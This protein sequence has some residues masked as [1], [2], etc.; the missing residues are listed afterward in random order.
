M[1]YNIV[2]VITNLSDAKLLFKKNLHPD[3]V[4]FR[5]DLSNSPF[6]TL[7]KI[8][9]LL[10]KT[11]IICTIRPKYEGGGYS[12]SEN[13]RL[14]LFEKLIPLC[15]IVDIELSSK[16]LKEVIRI[17]KKNKKKFIISY[18]NFDFTPSNN[19]L[20]KILK[21]GSKFSPWIIKIATLIK[22]DRDF[23][24][25]FDFCKKYTKIYPLGILPMGQK[26]IPGRIFF[27]FF[28]S[29]LA[30]GYASKEVAPGQTN[31]NSLINL[32]KIDPKK[33]QK[34]L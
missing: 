8:R 17:S 21:N 7:K 33:I 10:K 25:L 1:K 2:G 27:P 5:A 16:I 34:I 6:S 15:D 30:Y 31:I 20:K 11:K 26:G 28:G 19:E 9:K 4:E 32:R 22:K 12:F 18:H 23:W 24:R 29:K 13:S 3:L 14:R